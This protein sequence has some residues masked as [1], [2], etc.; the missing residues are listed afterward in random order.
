MLVFSVIKKIPCLAIIFSA[1][2]VTSCQNKTK[3]LL[4]KKW[5]CV[6]VENLTPVNKDFLEKEDSLVTAKLETALQDLSWTFN[7]DN[8]YQ[9]NTMGVTTVTGVYSISDD[10]KGLTC[11]SAK[12]NINRYS[13]S[14]LTAQEL[15]LKGY[16]SSVPVILYF[17]PH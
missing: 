2:A 4:V 7:A 10:G 16:T 14:T 9:C 11:T 6:K 5:D 13:I 15:V 1:V 8:T 12:N 3:Q 17:R